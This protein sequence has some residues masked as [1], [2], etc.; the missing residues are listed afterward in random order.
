MMPFL[1][2][3]IGKKKAKTWRIGKKNTRS[4]GKK[5]AKQRRERDKN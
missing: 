5:K 4:I 2:D 3:M 1:L